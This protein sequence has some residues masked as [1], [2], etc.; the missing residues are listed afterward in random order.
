MICTASSRV[1]A[2]I[3]RARL[4]NFAVCNRWM[5]V[6]NETLTLKRHRFA[7]TGLRLPCY[8]TTG[9]RQRR[10]GGESLNGCSYEPFIFKGFNHFWAGRSRKT[11]V[12]LM[13]F[14]HSVVEYQ[15]TI[16]LRESVSG[17]IKST[18]SWL[19]RHQHVVDEGE[20]NAPCL[21]PWS[22]I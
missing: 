7:S 5:K 4:V 22:Y 19:M 3:Q 12:L 18:F 2:M 13:C 17:E 1:G 11:S 14:A 15:L 9:Q 20:T 21:F 16:A 8:V 10:Q 6:N